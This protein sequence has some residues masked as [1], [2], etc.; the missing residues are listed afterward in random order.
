MPVSR[1][2]AV[3]AA[4]SCNKL[5]KA[6]DRLG[7]MVGQ[8]SDSTDDRVWMSHLVAI[9]IWMNDARETVLDI[10]SFL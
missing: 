2:A 5:L 3:L 6:I 8:L 4:A 9:Q 10:K 7:T 1:N